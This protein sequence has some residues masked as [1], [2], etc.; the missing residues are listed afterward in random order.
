M[1][2]PLRS[3]SDETHSRD[4]ESYS[5]EDPNYCD[6]PCSIRVCSWNT[7][8]VNN[9][10]FEYWVTNPNPAYDSLMQG[11]ESFIWNPENDFAINQILTDQMFSELCSELRKKEIDGIEKLEQLWMQDYRKRRAISEFLMDKAIGNKRLASMPDRLTNTIHLSDGSVCFRPTVINAYDGV[12]L[13]SVEAWW[14]AWIQFLFYTEVHVPTASKQRAAHRSQE[15]RPICRLIGPLLRSK[16]PAV[17]PE[18]QAISIPL[19]ILCL[20]ILDAI[21]IFVL[22]SVQPAGAWQAVRR[23]LCDGLIINKA[24][25]TCAIIAESYADCDVVLLQE[26]AAVLVELV[27]QNPTLHERYALLRPR[28]VDASRNQNSLIL[29]DRRRFREESII[30]VTSQVPSSCST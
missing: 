16:Y 12:S 23:E 1:I 20:A 18:E 3:R 13:D 14:S 30:D 5:Q 21:F 7:A 6:E 27:L 10:P 2:S 11:V 22:N 24:A 4:E 19:Q 26:A 17:T 28:T 15:A 25:R 9:N 8:A 29:A